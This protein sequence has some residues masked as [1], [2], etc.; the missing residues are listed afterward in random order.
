M[1]YELG[2]VRQAIVNNVDAIIHS[3][4][5]NAIPVETLSQRGGKLLQVVQEQNGQ[6][7]VTRSFTPDAVNYVERGDMTFTGA[8][9]AM[10]DV[11]NQAGIEILPSHLLEAQ[12]EFPFIAVSE[13]I[14]TN[15]SLKDMPT[16]LKVK[17]AQG[18][19][20]LVNPS[21]EIFPSLE[22]INRNMFMPTTRQDGTQC[23][24]LV[25]LDPLLTDPRLGRSDPWQSMYLEK[26]GDLFWDDWCNDDERSEVLGA[27]VVSVSKALSED[28]DM[29]GRTGG[30][31]MDLHLMS[32]GVD[33]RMLRR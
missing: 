19:G 10:H 4:I 16:E 12:G 30:A 8:W 18:F 33:N 14:D 31:F 29:T 25:D 1:S 2:E 3:R 24:Y 9:R 28:M 7:F 13:Y 23:V 11:F 22:M 17:L 20:Q 27:L 6:R 26:L 21:N 15:E 5:A 32:N